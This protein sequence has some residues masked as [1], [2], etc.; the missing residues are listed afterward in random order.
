MRPPACQSNCLAV[1]LGIW[2]ARPHRVALSVA[3]IGLGRESRGRRRRRANIIQITFGTDIDKQSGCAP[4]GLER[5]KRTIPSLNTSSSTHQSLFED[6]R[7]PFTLSAHLAWTSPLIIHPSRSPSSTPANMASGSQ[8]DA[9]LQAVMQALESLYRNPDSAVKDE[10]NRWLQDFQQTPEAWQTANSLLLAQNL[11]LEPRLFAAQTFRSKV[12]LISVV[13]SPDLPLMK[14]FPH[15]SCTDDIRS[16]PST[17]GC[18][19]A[20]QR[21]PSYSIRII[22]SWSESRTNAALPHTLCSR[23]PD[24]R[25]RMAG[26]SQRHDK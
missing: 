5:E 7:P 9:A 25:R 1:R 16:G 3:S 22:R 26:R 8:T 12:C 19:A 20:S 15:P 2:V 10:A 18:Q 17:T 21:H 13:S 11:P 6:S 14:P 23:Y 24:D 4:Q